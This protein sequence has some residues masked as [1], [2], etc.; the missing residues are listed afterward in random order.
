MRPLHIPLALLLLLSGCATPT[1][2]PK[3]PP[4]WRTYEKDGISLRLPNKSFTSAK[5][6]TLPK[7]VLAPDSGPPVDI[8]PQRLAI[9]LKPAASPIRFKKPRYYF[10]SESV[11]YITP[12]TDDTVANFDVAYDGLRN[13]SARLRNI[14]SNPRDLR[15][16][17]D[18]ANH[19]A[20]LDPPYLPSEP[21]NNAARQMHAKLGLVSSPQ[22]RG[23]RLLTYYANGKTGYGATNAELTYDFQGLTDDGRYYISA[24][25]G[26]RHPDLPE[27]MDD[28]RAASDATPAQRLQERTRLNA[29]PDKSYHPDLDTLDAILR[30]LK[31]SR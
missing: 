22:L 4:G 2:K 16:W 31:I 8:G 12:L 27:T 10:P 19:D 5:F 3:T 23:F 24:R 20:P 21:Y 17:L 18:D 13:T 14:L 28:P 26:V 30:S 1:K 11:I 15:P 9:Y 25:I 29:W 7:T 6:V